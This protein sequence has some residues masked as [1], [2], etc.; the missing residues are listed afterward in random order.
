MPLLASFAPR[1][2]NARISLLHS[3]NAN[4]FQVNSPQAIS[5]RKMTR[6]EDGKE[7][8]EENE[9][10]KEDER[11]NGEN[12]SGEKEDEENEDGQDEEKEQEK[13]NVIP[14]TLCI[15]G[16][17]LVIWLVL[18]YVILAPGPPGTCTTY[19]CQATAKLFLEN[20]SNKTDPC[21]DFYDFAC[22]N[23]DKEKKGPGLSD[24]YFDARDALVVELED[25]LVTQLSDPVNFGGSEAV[26]YIGAIYAQ[27]ANRCELKVMSKCKLQPLIALPPV[28]C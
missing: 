8:E 4:L 15:L 5:R 1:A 13:S 14:N 24:Y 28:Q 3:S 17:V 16:M 9:E 19:A 22:H 7:E 6:E 21:E 27:A 23:F 20:M 26:R 10:E 12:E 25:F 18:N 2:N 11:E